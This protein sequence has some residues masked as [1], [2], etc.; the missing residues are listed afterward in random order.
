MLFE[1]LMMTLLGN[2]PK[3]FKLHRNRTGWKCK[4]WNCRRWNAGH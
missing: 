2:R 4:T 3:S 1:M